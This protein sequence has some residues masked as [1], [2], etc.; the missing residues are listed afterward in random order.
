MIASTDHPRLTVIVPVYNA[1]PYLPACLDSLLA[2]SYPRERFEIIVV[3]NLS[4][5]QT[6]S[7][8]ERYPVKLLSCP[9]RGPAAA[10]NLGIRS[11]QAEILAFTDA[12][13]VADPGWL[14]HLVQPYQDGSVGGTAGEIR[15]Y[16][17]QNIDELDCF[18][19]QFPPLVNFWSGPGEYLPHLYTAN[20]SYRRE[21][22]LELGGF[23]PAM[24]T[25]ED[26]ELSWRLQLN[27]QWSVAYAPL[28]VIYHRHRKSTAALGRQF[29]Q[30]GFGEIVLDT[31]FGKQPG[32]PRG[33]AF[34]F[35]R[36][37][38][39]LLRLPVY[40]AAIL[41]RRVRLARGQISGMEAG[42]PRLSLLIEYNNI[43]GKLEAILATRLMTDARPALQKNADDQIS[44][45]Y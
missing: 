37:A 35:R 6:A 32:Y 44:K 42:Y 29:R 21:T 40:T 14:A 18:L 8:V 20:A 16:L 10:R 25:G 24:L 2:L 36:I 13:C 17:N 19:E 4:T 9:Q 34:Q 1:A 23:N 11:S 3:D 26:V 39:Q 45:F 33:R 15:A 12:D 38:H 43:V 27:T 7:L 30:Y 22:L 41:T 5:D 28:A 31:L